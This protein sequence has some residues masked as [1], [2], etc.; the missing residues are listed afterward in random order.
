MTIVIH[1]GAAAAA[2]AVARMREEEELMTPYTRDDL[3][4][5]WEFKILRSN[6]G[7]F[8]KPER[9]KQILDDEAR[10][11]WVL[12]EKFDNGRLRLKRPRTAK[13]NDPNLDFDPYRTQVGL[14]E[15]G[16]VMMILGLV[17]GAFLA[18]GAL[19]ALIRA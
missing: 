15:G 10:A 5:D 12:V 8:R 14:S 17:L 4:A 6:T 18:I 13:G 1:G 9:L 7:G 19:V 2:A 11:G 16:L 3:A